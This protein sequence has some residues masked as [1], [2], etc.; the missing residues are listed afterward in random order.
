MKRTLQ[1][2]LALFCAA[3]LSVT[4][5]SALSVEEA[6][7]LLEEYYVN[8]I[9]ASAYESETLD[10]LFSIVGD[11][12]TYYMDANAYERF[13][14]GVESESSV[15]GIG[16][17]VRF[18]DEGLVIL[19]VLDGGGA[20]DAG[21]RPGDVIIAINGE[22]CVPG[23]DQYI[24]MIT[25]EAGTVVDVTVRRDDGAERTFSIV[26]KLIELR[27]TA[28]S[29]EDGVG[30]IDCASFGSRTAAYFSEGLQN[31][32]DDA[33]VWV[34]DLRGNGGGYASAAVNAVGAFTGPGVKLYF[35]DRGRDCTPN[36]YWGGALAKAPA[37][38]LVNGGTAS[39]SEIFSGDI[40]A[41]NAGIVVG[42]RTYGK[43]LAQLVFDNETDPDLFDDD[44]VKISIS[45]FYCSDGNTTDRIGVL[46][47][48]YVSDALAAPVAELLCA[49][50]PASGDSLRLT[51][52]GNEFWVDLSK[53]RTEAYRAAF[54]ELLSALPPDAEMRGTWNGAEAVLSPEDA[55]ERFGV[56]VTSRSFTDVS[57]SPYALQINTLGAYGILSGVGGRRF[58]PSR[59]LTRA[60]L[61]AMLAQALDVSSSAAGLFIDVTPDSWYSGDVNAMA[62]LGFVNGVG[63]RRFAPSGTLTQEQFIAVMGRLARFLNFRVDNYARALADAQLSDAKLARFRPWARVEA[64]AL[65]DY[66]G[67]L[68][69]T[70]PEEIDPLAPVTREQAAATLCNMLKGLDLLSY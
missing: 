39:A 10:E 44:A 53:A 27:N 34:V 70:S 64:A 66:A 4:S 65:T 42:S 60:E 58:D 43:G 31:Y 19:S 13:N 47:T 15:T 22:S 5:V 18:T 52:N 20:K 24:Q 9:P 11:P 12:Y 45:R 29:L 23:G 21:L 49:E 68:L 56:S 36:S 16:V 25:G 62:S 40:R 8:E 3:L 51:L 28:V 57:A 32:A 6:I 50:K 17:S 14:A 2:L 33:R 41:E 54:S 1:R 55:A 48:I 37:I 7:S 38:V 59:A 63:S 46:P 67:N 61:C 26:R 69:Y 35:L 30:V